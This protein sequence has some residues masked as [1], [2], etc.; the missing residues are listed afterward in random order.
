MISTLLPHTEFLE[1]LKDAT[2]ISNIRNLEEK[3][4]RFVADAEWHIGY[5]TS[6]VY[7]FV[8]YENDGT[9]FNGKDLWLPKDC[10]ELRN[11]FD[12]ERELCRKDYHVTGNYVYFQKGREPK[13]PVIYYEALTFDG[14]GWPLMS[15]NHKEALV[16]YV[17]WKLIRPKAFLSGN[18]S[19]RALVNDYE[20]EWERR[21][22]AAR[23]EDVMPGS[24]QEMERAMATWNSSKLELAM[25]KGCIVHESKY[26]I[27]AKKDC[28][29]RNVPKTVEVYHWQY[30]DLVTNISV[31]PS[32]DLNW[33]R[34][35][36]E[37]ETLAEMIQ[38]KTI[39]YPNI[40][41]IAFA[42][43]GVDP[44]EYQIYDILNHR[45]D[46]NVFDFYYNPVLNMQVFIS[47][48]FY[49]I[50]NIYFKFVKRP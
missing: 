47:K 30:D 40:G 31:A 18:R 9:N 23:G 44:G 22:L 39:P 11:I 3:I 43:Q 14:H 8:A 1:S 50:S 6:L 20:D 32:I 12:G 35:N 5:N 19:D 15:R 17:T 46:D 36:A 7:K 38:G 4:K 28:V 49:S 10:W 33:L 45:V 27:E 48:E 21:K 13:N 41:R 29:L 34:E 16:S 37:F 42:I 26:A 2:D 25:G 24:E